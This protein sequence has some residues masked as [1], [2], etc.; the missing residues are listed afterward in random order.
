MPDSL[1]A[2]CGAADASWLRC[3]NEDP[4]AAAH[5]P[6][7]RSREVKSGHYVR[8]APTPLRAPGLAMHSPEL[9]ADL[10]LDAAAVAAAGF[11]EFFGGD[12]GAL[13]FPA[14][15]SWATPYALS[16]MG[17]PQTR[18]CPSARRRLRRRPRSPSERSSR[19]DGRRYELQLKGGGQTPF[20]R[21]A[22]GAP[23]CGRRCA[24]SSEAMHFLGVERRELCRRR[25]GGDD[26]A[27]LVQ[28]PTSGRA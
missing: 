18:N 15:E 4:E 5:A 28:R 26:A 9:A 25:L 19:R 14:G 16:I 27:A 3:L 2:F 6:N 12:H 22:D 17:E 7:K 11:A 10:G 8:V 21:G 20:C 13:P 24:S 1:E 23:C